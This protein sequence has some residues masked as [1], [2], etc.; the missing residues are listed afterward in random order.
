VLADRV[1]QLRPG[2]PFLFVSGFSGHDAL[3]EAAG[4]REDCRLLQKPFS[5]NELGTAVRDALDDAPIALAS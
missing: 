1:E 4:G 3:G 5:A 2:T